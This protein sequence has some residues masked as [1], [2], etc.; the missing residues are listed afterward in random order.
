M[1]Y[2]IN[3]F[4]EIIDFTIEINFTKK[5]REIVKKIITANKKNNSISDSILFISKNTENDI[6]TLK[7]LSNKPITYSIKQKQKYISGEF[8]LIYSTVSENEKIYLSLADELY[9]SYKEMNFFSYIKFNHMICFAQKDTYKLYTYIL[10]NKRFEGT[11]NFSLLEFKDI[12]GITKPYERY[13]DFEKNVISPIVNDI[14]TIT[15]YTIKIDK[16]HQSKHSNSKIIGVSITVLN[17]Y[18]YTQ[19]DIDLLNDLYNINTELIDNNVYSIL[20]RYMK[21]HDYEYVYNNFIYSKN[22]FTGSFIEFLDKSL[23][24]NLHNKYFDPEWKLIKNY[25]KNKVSLFEIQGR[26]LKMIDENFSK[27]DVSMKDK[28]I[29]QKNIYELPIKKS[30]IFI[31]SDKKL[32]VDYSEKN[33]CINIYVK[34]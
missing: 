27:K 16:I 21:K 26:I 7:K 13:Y 32:K 1:I 12:L 24:K 20:L 33:I 31:R 29:L 17:K 6:K 28:I 3:N 18:I 23:E 4:D 22:N 10:K 5:E 14:N 30:I 34:V 15:D 11:L 2:R 19:K 25:S 9:Q 8:F